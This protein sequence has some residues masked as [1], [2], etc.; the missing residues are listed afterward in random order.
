M[1]QQSGGPALRWS[2]FE[3]RYR[4]CA[5]IL[6]LQRISI[7]TADALGAL[8]QFSV[9]AVLWCADLRAASR[10]CCRRR[11]RLKKKRWGHVHRRW[12]HGE[13]PR[14]CC[15]FRQ[16]AVFFFFFFC[17]HAVSHEGARLQ[18]KR[19]HRYVC[20]WYETELWSAG[21]YFNDQVELIQF[22]HAWMD[23]TKRKLKNMYDQ[24]HVTVE[25]GW[26]YRNTL[27]LC[28]WTGKC[29]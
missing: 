14:S 8:L 22:M 29:R 18:M 13:S 10:C 3:A 7:Y 27:E 19:A 1:A 6:V 28:E 23:D 17:S 4:L 11:R 20:L 12:A 16:A 21:L 26:T 2:M 9:T 5:Y 25:Y 15:C 24:K